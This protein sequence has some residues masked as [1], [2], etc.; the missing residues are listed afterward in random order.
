MENRFL[1]I[2]FAAESFHRELYD[3]DY[4]EPSELESLVQIY[5]AHTPEEH[6]EW[7]SGKLR[8]ANSPSLRRR[9]QELAKRA[10]PGIQSLIPN[11]G[12]WANIVAQVRNDLTHLRSDA[13]EFNSDDLYF[14]SESIYAVVR[15]CML[16]EAGVPLEMLTRKMTEGSA[17]WYGTQLSDAMREASAVIERNAQSRSSN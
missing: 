11:R 7:L 5:I 4:M 12:Y 8:Y 13:E 1:N 6:H 14:L 17:A 3:A 15:L 16:L 2:A 9:L 10:R